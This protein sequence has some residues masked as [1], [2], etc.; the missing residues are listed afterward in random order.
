MKVDARRIIEARMA[1]R[2]ALVDRARR[3]AA[4]LGPDL[5]VAAVVVFGSVAR[6]D[7]NLWSDVDVLVVVKE[8]DD[9]LLERVRSAGAAIGLV[10]PVVWTPEQL[11]SRLRRND[12]IAV[13]S[14]EHGI[15]LIGS[16]AEVV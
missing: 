8:V 7:F 12:P 4:S 10:E 2:Q 3:F 15:W 16:P 1:E 9:H 11:R 14:V 6:G 5:G 13:E